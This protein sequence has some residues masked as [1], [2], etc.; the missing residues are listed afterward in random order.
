MS[1]DVP[2]RPRPL[3]SLPSQV[4]LAAQHLAD[5]EGEWYLCG[6]WAVDLLLG[7]E[8]RSHLD[9]DIVV[10]HDEQA[11]LHRHLQGWRALGHDDAVSETHPDPWDGRELRVPAH[12]HA[13]IDSMGGT[14]LDIQ[15][16][17]RD[18][19]DWVL[20]DNPRITLAHDEC[21]DDSG[22][23]GI[24]MVSA[25]VVLYFKAAARGWRQ[26]PPV[27]AAKLRDHDRADFEV[28][29]PTLTAAQRSWLGRAI[30][31]HDPSH[32]WLERLTR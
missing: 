5:Y 4:R 21:V 22:H 11:L 18:G 10:F 9:V 16:N 32:P 17:R 6:G 27:P 25:P 15:V 1:S 20:C 19:S 12:V 14:E 2:G 8:T 28:L 29:E 30:A 23:W 13:N 3:N 7:E 31:A 26:A 24:P